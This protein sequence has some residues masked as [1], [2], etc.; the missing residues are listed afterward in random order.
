MDSTDSPDIAPLSATP[1]ICEKCRA[2]GMAGDAAFADIPDLLAF[3]PV[4]RRPHANGWTPEH[5]RAFI[6]ALAITGSPRQAARQVGRATFGAEQMRTAKGGRSFA[7]AWDAAIE[8]A[9]ERE[10]ARLHEN[11]GELAAKT[12]EANASAKASG[13]L[14]PSGEKDDGEDSTFDQQVE[15]ARDRILDRLERLRQKQLRDIMDDP[16]KC[17]AWDLLH[18]PE[19]WDRHRRE[20]RLS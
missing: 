13:R 15:E 1:V 18:E 16:E 14:V 7:A 12:E 11:L 2:T 17:A 6:A 8:I 20:L 4:P 3:E 9:R 10:L 5:Q 19:D